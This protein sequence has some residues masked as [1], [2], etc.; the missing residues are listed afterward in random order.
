MKTKNTRER[1]K[2]K[3]ATLILC[4]TNDN[5]QSFKE[6]DE[7]RGE[8]HPQYYQEKENYCLKNRSAT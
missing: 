4:F 3:S 6:Q 2:Y 8:A 5:L 1:I 7:E